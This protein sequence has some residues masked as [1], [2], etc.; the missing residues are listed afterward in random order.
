MIISATVLFL[1]EV[2]AMDI[3][4]KK[5]SLTVVAGCMSSGK[6]LEMLRLLRRAEIARRSVQ[7]LVPEIDTR[8]GANVTSRDGFSRP[9][10]VVTSMDE[11]VRSGEISRVVTA[12]VVGIDEAQFFDTGI[13]RAVNIMIDIGIDVIVAGLDTNFRGEPFA[14]MPQLLAL[15]DTVLKLDAV[16]VVCGGRA[17]RSQR[18]ESAPP[19]SADSPASAFVGGDESYG[20]R[21]RDCHVV[22]R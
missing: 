2:R 21:C 12:D 9:A 22:P 13:V 20:A 4:L 16:C 6:S 17:T 7:V 11:F 5:G 10:I 14:S 18:L 8:S 3:K 19:V 15:A 1:L